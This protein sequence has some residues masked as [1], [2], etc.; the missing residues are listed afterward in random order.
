MKDSCIATRTSSPG[1]RPV[2][3][4]AAVV[5]LIWAAVLAVG[6]CTNDPANPLGGGLIDNQIDSTLSFLEIAAIESFAGLRVDDSDEL[7][8]DLPTLYLG[9][10]GGNE[11][12]FVVNFD[13]SD[14]F[15]EAHPAED[16]TEE[17][18]NT[19]KLSLT[20]YKIYSPV[21][22][23]ITIDGTTLEPD[24]TF[25]P[26]GYPTTLYFFVHELD[27]P[28]E[29]S[30]VA[31]YPGTVP[32]FNT[33]AINNDFFE[34]KIGLEPRLDLDVPT[35]LRW[36]NGGVKVGLFVELGDLSDPGMVGFASKE[37]LFASE[38]PVLGAGTLPGPNII[39]DFGDSES[40][41]V[42]GDND[43]TIYEAVAE[44]PQTQPE[45]ADGFVLRTGLRNYPTLRFDLSQLPTNAVINRAVLSVVNDTSRSFGPDFS[46]MISEIVASVMDDPSGRLDVSTIGDSTRVYPLDYR[47]NLRPSTDYVIEFP[48]TTGIRRAVNRVNEE[49]RGFLLSGVEDPGIFPF[50]SRP[51]D[52]TEPSYYF[53]QMNF[54]GLNDPDPANRPKLKI[55]YS[56]VDELSGA[57]N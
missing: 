27:S 3:L 8:Q 20:K 36:V 53:R 33:A 5:A 35:F 29:N 12:S 37:W 48:I 17:N 44:A 10:E 39:V 14:I 45:A 7:I 52:V 23:I 24:T 25:V 40:T 18:I 47:A 56:V 13:F 32:A 26:T 51:P 28:F 16:Y 41:L 2:V 34:G 21:E 11:T 57:G 42:S 30:Q 38:L 49:S 9:D 22:T 6:G 43:A 54:L 19:V 15:T 31:E 50:G 55:W 46:V 1:R 4:A